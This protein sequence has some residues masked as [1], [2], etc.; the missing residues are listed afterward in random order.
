MA[1]TPSTLSQGWER[2]ITR[3]APQ[4]AKDASLLANEHEKC[5]SLVGTIALLSVKEIC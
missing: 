4:I 5:M 3:F 1:L 2:G